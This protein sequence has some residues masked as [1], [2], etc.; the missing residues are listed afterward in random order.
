MTKAIK[1]LSKWSGVALF[2]LLLAACGQKLTQEN[3]NKI[4]NGMSHADVVN[5]LGEPTSSQGGGMLGIT[6][7]TSVWREKNTE[8]TVIFVN[9]K[10]TSKVL[11]ERPADAAP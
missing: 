7:S 5:I 1:Q 4:N 11:N 9:D 10:V 8:L 2:A 3:F 6:A